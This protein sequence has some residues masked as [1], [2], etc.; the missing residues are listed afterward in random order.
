MEVGFISFHLLDIYYY[1][2]DEQ[3]IQ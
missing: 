2:H 3:Q 1:I